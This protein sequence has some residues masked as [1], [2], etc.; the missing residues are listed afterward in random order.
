MNFLS[1]IKQR[2]QKEQRLQQAQAVT[3]IAGQ[4]PVFATY[5]G[6]QYKVK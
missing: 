2:I 1:L 5:R 6:V 4:R 3:T